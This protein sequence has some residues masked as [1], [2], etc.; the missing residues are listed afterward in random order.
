[1]ADIID[2]LRAKYPEQTANLSDLDLVRAVAKKR[3]KLRDKFTKA[4]MLRTDKQIAAEEP[5]VEVPQ[6]T[7][8]EQKRFNW[9]TRNANVQPMQDYAGHPGT[10]VSRTLENVGQV[11]PALETAGQVVTGGIAAPIAGV[12][13]LASVA[14]NLITGQGVDKSLQKGAETVGK[15]SEALTYQ[16]MT[17]RGQELSE[18]AMY[19]LTKLQQAAGGAGDL[20]E[21]AGYPNLAATVATGIEAAPMAIGAKSFKPKNIQTQLTKVAGDTRKAVN[22]AMN[23]AIAP[24]YKN[25]RTR[26]QSKTY[27]NKALTAVEKIVDTEN[28]LRFKDEYGVETAGLPESRIDF[29]DAISQTKEVIHEGYSNAAL[30]ADQKALRHVESINKARDIVSE[31][32]KPGGARTLAPE[33]VKEAKALVEKEDYNSLKAQLET[34]QAHKLYREKEQEIAQKGTSPERV[35]DLEVA[36]ERISDAASKLEPLRVETVTAAKALDEVINSIPLQD[37]APAVI[38]YATKQKE[39]LLRRAQGG[40]VVPSL[41]NKKPGGYTATDAQ[42]TIQLLN[43]SVQA[44]EKTPS[45]ANFGMAMVDSL[46]LNRLR[47]SLDKTVNRATGKDYQKAKNDYAALKAIEDDIAKAANKERNKIAGKLLPSFSDIIASHQVISGLVHAN[48]ASIAGGSVVKAL[49]TVRKRMMAEDPKIKKMFKTV[50]AN[51]ALERQLK[52]QQAIEASKKIGDK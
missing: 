39:M 40:D 14:K 32:E 27:E 45:T 2:K 26:T 30:L 7:P 33:K 5:G 52:G 51:Q 10:Q 8:E 41:T 23:K 44:Y 22:T 15:V 24:A 18:S 21:E 35:K 38:E 28:R 20:I 12:T 3:P 47:K 42:F 46:A 9:E 36:M 6:L 29:Q 25:R 48:P 11:Y 1:M 50:K 34:E 43:K 19:P 4:Y 17:T 49:G 13:G 16:P 31:S 37:A